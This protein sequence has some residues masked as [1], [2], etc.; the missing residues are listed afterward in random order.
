LADKSAPQFVPP[1]Q[2][3]GPVP[4]DVTN[5]AAVGRPLT[6]TPGP[7]LPFKREAAEGKDFASEAIHLTL[8][9]EHAERLTAVASAAATSPGVVLLAAWCA[10]LARWTGEPDLNVWV[11]EGKWIG[12]AAVGGEAP[13][14]RVLAVQVNADDALPFE[15]LVGQVR[16]ALEGAAQSAQDVAVPAAREDAAAFE[17]MPLPPKRD[18]SISASRQQSRVARFGVRLS[19]AMIEGASAAVEAEL[20]FN[21]SLFRRE[22]AARIASSFEA[23]ATSASRDPKAKVGALDL[24]DVAERGRLLETQNQT[25]APFPEHQC[26]HELFEAQVARVPDRPALA[27]GDQR[28]TYAELNQRANQ[29][30]HYLQKRGVKPNTCVGLFVERSLEMIVG[31]LG[32]LKAGGAYVPL[33]PDSP[34][35][36]LAHQLGEIESPVILTQEKL[37]GALPEHSAEVVCM[38][39]D[40]PRLNAESPANPEH[41]VRPKD[42]AYVIYTSGS[43]GTPKG[44]AVKH[45]NLVNY[46]HFLCRK[47]RTAE[48]DAG[49]GLSFATV[50]TI[51]ADLG[52]TCIFPSL[53]SGGCLHVIGHDMGMDGELFGAYARRHP[54]DVLK[55]TPSHLSALLASREGKDILPRRFLVTGGEAS[56]WNLVQRVRAMSGLCWINHY[57]PTETTIGSLTFDLDGNEG[58]RE[59]AATVPIGRPI[60]NT[61]VYVLDA[62]K[63]PVP[64]GVVGELFIAGRGVTRGYLKQPGQTADRF[65]HDPFVPDPSA[66][67]YRTGDRVRY[68]PNGAIEF[69]GRV[70]H[71]VKVRGF[72]IEL[73]EIEVALRQHPGVREVIV[74]ARRDQPDDVR[75]VAYLVPAKPP[76]PGMAELRSFLLKQL[77]EHMV[78]SAFVVL[79]ALPLT[80]NGKVDRKRLLPP[81]EAS[82]GEQE[83]EGPAKAIAR[84]DIEAELVAIWKSVIGLKSIGITD[85]FF[86]IGGHSLAALHMLAQ[87]EQR[88]GKKLPNATLFHSATIEKMAAILRSK[89][90]LPNWTSL[91]PIQPTGTKP[92]LFC[93]HGGGGHVFYYRDLARYLGADQP[94]YGLQAWMGE[95]GQERHF[96]VEDMAVHYLNEIRTVSPKGPYYLC[97]ASFGG[98]VAFEMAKMLQHQGE[99]VGLVAMFDT[100]GPGYPKFRPEVTKL[101]HALYWFIRRVEHHAGGVLLL[102]S[103]DRLPYLRQKAHQTVA[104]T[105]ESLENL[106]KDAQRWT[107]KVRGLEVPRYLERDE[108]FIRTA[109]AAYAPTPYSGRVLLFRSDKQPLGIYPDPTLGWSKVVQGE[110]EVHETPGYHAAIVVEPRVRFLVERFKPYLEKAQAEHAR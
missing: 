107:R 76:A 105:R 86:E 67:M 84:D 104:D 2:E 66:R 87:V 93:V 96:R 101:E 98:K 78:P 51:A 36:R 50:S 25:A 90:A 70:D 17:H 26:F 22:D 33:L 48:F 68:L 81:G 57:G 108:G 63:K 18:C 35:V 72:R 44:V 99:E 47:L 12:G 95:T 43:T 37:L 85:N 3:P 4:H 71:Q 28:L 75:I 7:A 41:A 19:T 79:D 88:L 46:T 5:A 24:L 64:I 106:Y 94:F 11:A 92:P 9:A 56:T 30:A 23:L 61:R 29:I 6:V 1:S 58:V 59:F 54:I 45:E 60:A 102:D 21:T 77:P 13:S 100:W 55:I 82:F 49:G 103:K 16:G 110:L 15:D 32:I 52:N 65:V 91:V 14:A 38:D 31:L 42:I 40:L 69:L 89:E 8:S 20:Q 109:S 80:P 53:A 83:K 10:L 27:F 73:G 74:I 34:K 97:G 62:L 39:R